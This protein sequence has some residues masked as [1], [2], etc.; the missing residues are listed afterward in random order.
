MFISKDL[1]HFDVFLDG[2]T[3]Q[4]LICTNYINNVPLDKMSTEKYDN[5]W[6]LRKMVPHLM[7]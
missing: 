4:K 3:S 6:V 7:F 2:E 1:E 5:G